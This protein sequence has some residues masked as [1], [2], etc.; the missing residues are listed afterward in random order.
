MKQNFWTSQNWI[1]R[2]IT[3]EL[4]KLSS[5][6][7]TAVCGACR[8]QF[9]RKIPTRHEYRKSSMKAFKMS[10]RWLKAVSSS[11]PEPT[12]RPP[13]SSSTIFLTGRSARLG[14][15]KILPLQKMPEWQFRPTLK[16]FYLPN[17]IRTQAIL[18]SPRSKNRRRQTDHFKSIV[19]S[20]AN[21][22]FWGCL[23]KKLTLSK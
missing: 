20:L 9:Q 15:S 22:D 1:S 7:A 4:W 18:C 13:E 11:L 19:T 10:G 3:F 14:R 16:P 23:F 6:R 5:L 21:A 12:N 2:I 8:Q 17:S